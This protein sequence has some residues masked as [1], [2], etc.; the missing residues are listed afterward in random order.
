MTHSSFFGAFSDDAARHIVAALHKHRMECR[1]RWISV[2]EGV[3]LLESVLSG[4]LLS[5]PESSVFDA[6]P[7]APQTEVVTPAL[8]TRQQA[9]QRLRC[10]IST[11]DRL[12]RANDLSSLRIGRS[13][14]IRI[15]DIDRYLDQGATTTC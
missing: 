3:A 8:A 10:S 5:R 15:E 7:D 4:Q 6:V 11:V 13:V 1:T 14:R 12:L 2:P 9:A